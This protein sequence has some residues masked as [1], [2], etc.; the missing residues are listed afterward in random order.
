MMKWKVKI[1]D[2]YRSTYDTLSLNVQSS[3]L[4]FMF[5]NPTF[6]MEQTGANKKTIAKQL[7]RFAHRYV[8][9]EKSIGFLRHLHTQTKKPAKMLEE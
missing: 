2:Q 1:D 3:V 8:A 6:H 9:G 5:E 7:P 4:Y